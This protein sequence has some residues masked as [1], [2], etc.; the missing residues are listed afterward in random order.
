M[1]IKLFIC[2]CMVRNNTIEIRLEHFCE[3]SHSLKMIS[4]QRKHWANMDSKCIRLDKLWIFVKRCNHSYAF[5]VFVTFFNVE[6]D[7]NFLEFQR[8]SWTMIEHLPIWHKFKN[9]EKSSLTR[10]PWMFKI[11]MKNHKIFVCL[12]F[13]RQLDIQN[14]QDWSDRRYFAQ[15]W[16]LI[17]L[18][19][20]KIMK[21]F[22]KKLQRNS[23]N[24]L[25]PALKYDFS[26]DKHIWPWT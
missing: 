1:Y 19:R 12:W 7:W 9:F 17:M 23:E 16:A 14:E 26:V 21:I 20:S 25:P 18:L 3:I 22:P 5:Y 24:F 15:G 10:Y 2:P 13:R 8:F 4:F 11:M 6:V